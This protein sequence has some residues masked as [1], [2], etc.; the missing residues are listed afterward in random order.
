[1]KIVK[2]LLSAL[3][4]VST[5]FFPRSTSYAEEKT[6]KD[7]SGEETDQVIISLKS[8]KAIAKLAAED[9]NELETNDEEILVTAKVPDGRTLDDFI[10]ELESNPDVEYVEPDHMLDITYTPNDPYLSYQYHHDRINSK[11]A[12]DRTKGSSDVKVAVL[13]DGFDTNHEEL[14]YQIHSN[15]STASTFSTNDHGTH[16][17]GI[18][19]ASMNNSTY[20]SGVAPDSQLVLIDVFETDRAYTSD[21]I[22]GIYI[23]VDVD[24]DIINMSLG[25]Y[26]YNSSFD[27]AV[28][29]AHNNGLVIVAAAGNDAVNIPMYPASYNNVISVGSTDNYDSR[30]Y[31]SNYGT[32]IDIVAP[33]SNIWSTLPYGKFGGMSG[34]SM[35]SPIVAGVAALIKSNEPNL[36]NIEIENRLIE[37]A[38]DLGGAGYDI[39]YGHGKVDAATALKILN[40]KAPSIEPVYENSIEIRGYLNHHVE[41][42]TIN[43]YKEGIIATQTNYYGNSEFRIPIPQ[44]KGGVIL[45]VKIV[46]VYGNVSE[47]KKV[48]VKD[49][50]APTSPTV[51]EV[52]DKAT[53]VT[54][55]AEIGSSITVKAGTTVLGKAT[56]TA[57]GKYSVTIAKQKAGT[58]LTVTATDSAG[59]VSEVKQVTVKDVTAPNK[60]VVDTITA[61]ST[62]LTGK[63]EAKS[64]I[65]VKKL[66]QVIGT[67]TTDVNGNFKVEIPVQTVGTTLAITATDGAGNKS[68]ETRVIVEKYIP[69]EVKRISGV[70]RYLTA[71]SI[72][73]TGWEKSDV[74]VLATGIDFPDALAGGPLAYMHN[75][76]ILLTQPTKLNADTKSEI[77]RLKAKKVIILGST[78]AVSAGIEKEL[79]AMGL[80]VERI[81]GEN[82][83]ET[84]ALIAKKLP[85]SKVVISNGFN[86]PDVLSV[87]AYASKNGI[88]ILLTRT[89]QL[90]EETKQGLV[91]K[92]SS[93]VIGGTGVI[94]NQVQGQLPSPKRYGGV[95]RY[96]TAS[97]VVKNL[98]MGTDIA[99]VA[100]GTNFPDALAGSVLAA[101]NNA[102]ILLVKANTIPDPTKTL[103]K[104]FEDFAIFGGS[105]AV[106]DKIK[107]ELYDSL[108]Q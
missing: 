25:G 101:K 79:K 11:K 100:T 56:T 45:Q 98:E 40:I 49:V 77:I 75:A 76:P 41:N 28:Q 9:L 90:P 96:S 89:D 42:A 36:S 105:G 10:K 14:R 22:T 16:V 97:E 58:K 72:A 69:S 93:I 31:F 59:N 85:S 86:F 32:T 66:N 70:D 21:I 108:L 65:E 12:W 104:N 15:Y 54:G 73:K 106:S 39:Y 3:L 71:T 63:A 52:T 107:Q 102:N 60:P 67:I 62:Y 18:I 83:F 88:P 84:A 23:A 61:K 55:T 48:T 64:V 27:A 94:S 44:Q 47:V 37:T 43:V 46:D 38:V 74:V 95:D 1:M 53:S 50:T 5:L 82:R 81:G 80:S 30:S 7:L 33:G 6:S 17:S 103:L 24:A 51:N 26:Y 92:T 2:I 87:S 99:Y 20:G 78:G 13:D 19:G 57:E 68:E 34:T 4:I 29:Y 91:G 35:A 8:E